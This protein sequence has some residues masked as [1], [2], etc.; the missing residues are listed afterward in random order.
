MTDIIRKNIMS[1]FELER[2]FC[3]DEITLERPCHVDSVGLYTTLELATTAMNNVVTDDLGGEWQQNFG[4]LIRER[5]VDADHAYLGFLSLRTYDSKGELNDEF[6][7]D[8]EGYD[9]FHGRDPL[10]LRYKV[11]GIVWCLAYDCLE[12]CIVG[13][14]PPTKEWYDKRHKICLEKYKENVFQ[15]DATDDCYGIYS[16][17]DGDTHKHVLC[18]EVFAANEDI[19]ESLI[20]ALKA[21]L[22]EMN[23]PKE[24]YEQL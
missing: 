18:A 19:P 8:Y 23:E 20:N 24:G 2:I 9:T 6:L 16:I 14:L 1:I 12:L 17:G 7:E 22:K 15:L 5:A 13:W 10:K 3:A 11:G 21:K 4:Y